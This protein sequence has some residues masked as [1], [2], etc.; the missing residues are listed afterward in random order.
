[1]ARVWMTKSIGVTAS[2]WMMTRHSGSRALSL[3][4]WAWGEVL[5]SGS[6]ANRGEA[7]LAAVRCGAQLNVGFNK[8]RYAQCARAH[9]AGNR[10]R[11]IVDG[12]LAQIEYGFEGAGQGLRLG[13]VAS[14]HDGDMVF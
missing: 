13:Q 3:P 1:M 12:D 14:V 5:M 2:L 9:V 4:G 7:L 10:R 6:I 8:E 11:Y